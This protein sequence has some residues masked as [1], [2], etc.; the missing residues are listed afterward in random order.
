MSVFA[1][2]GQRL[3]QLAALSD[4]LDYIADAIA[5]SGEQ[6]NTGNDLQVRMLLPKIRLPL[7]LDDVGHHRLAGQC[8]PHCWR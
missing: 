5:Q 8:Y 1:A 4:S 6:R 2:D 3:V 7:V